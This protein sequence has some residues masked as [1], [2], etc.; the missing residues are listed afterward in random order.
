[1]ILDIG[2]FIIVEIGRVGFVLLL[3]MLGG[4]SSDLIDL[5]ALLLIFVLQWMDVVSLDPFSEYKL[6]LKV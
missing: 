2:Q 4:S 5:N 1:M 3:L 6:N